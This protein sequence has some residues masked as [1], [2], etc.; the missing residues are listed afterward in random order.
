MFRHVIVAAALVLGLGSAQARQADLIEPGRVLFTRVQETDATLQRARAVILKAAAELGWS[1]A[2]DDPGQLTLK[3]NKQ[4]RHEVVLAVQYDPR[5]FEI[6]YV[7]STNMNYEAS[8]GKAKIHPNYNKWVANLI[9]KIE[10][11][12]MSAAL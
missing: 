11:G 6:K 12:Q 7:A 3:Y 9:K 8:D 1:A 4:G 5:G 10:L 2:Q